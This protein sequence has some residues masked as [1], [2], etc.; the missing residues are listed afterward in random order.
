MQSGSRCLNR[1]FANN[2]PP[3]Y[4]SGNSP[5][6]RRRRVELLLGEPSAPTDRSVRVAGNLMRTSR[7]LPARRLRMRERET[8]AMGTNGR[9]KLCLFPVDCLVLQDYKGEPKGREARGKKFYDRACMHGRKDKREEMTGCVVPE[10][11][12]REPPGAV[13]GP[14]RRPRTPRRSGA[15]GCPSTQYILNTYSLVHI[16]ANEKNTCHI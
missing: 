7:I 15:A 9:I 8:T 12:E 2:L 5:L 10:G 13:Q 11:V 1:L 14:D 3:P 4:L 6:L 16:T